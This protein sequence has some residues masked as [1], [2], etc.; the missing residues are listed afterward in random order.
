MADGPAI[1]LGRFQLTSIQSL[2]Q[3]PFVFNRR[4]NCC[5]LAVQM[6]NMYCDMAAWRFSIAAAAAVSAQNQ[7]LA[8]EFRIVWRQ[9]RVGR[10]PCN[11][12][13]E[14]TA[15]SSLQGARR[16]WAGEGVDLPGPQSLEA[17]R[18]SWHQVDYL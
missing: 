2:L 14:F 3:D 1:N 4:G 9:M 5:S 17:G 15:A 11:S 6:L 16:C 8:K 10:L 7:I 18:P 13:L 12:L